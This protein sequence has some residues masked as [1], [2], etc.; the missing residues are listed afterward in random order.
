MFLFITIFHVLMFLWIGFAWKLDSNCK[1]VFTPFLVYVI[2]DMVF[3]WN[4]WLLFQD[5]DLAVSYDAVFLSMI[6]IFFFVMGYVSVTTYQQAKPG[7]VL[8]STRLEIYLKQPLSVYY[9]RTGYLAI[10]LFLLL[11]SGT[12]LGIDKVT[13]AAFSSSKFL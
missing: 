2:V 6:A 12:S 5:L 7:G 8:P 10:I 11:V 9:N 4:Y 13:L 1:F 3:S